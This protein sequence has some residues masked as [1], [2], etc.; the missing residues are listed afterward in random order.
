M[1]LDLR[2]HPAQVDRA[3]AWAPVWVLACLQAACPTS[4]DLLVNSITAASAKETLLDRLVPA[5]PAAPVVLA[6]LGHLLRSMAAEEALLKVLKDL[7]KDPRDTATAN[8]AL[9]LS[10]VPCRSREV[11]LQDSADHHSR[12]N[13][14][15]D[16]R[17]LPVVLAVPAD[18]EVLA[19]ADHRSKARCRS[20]LLV[21]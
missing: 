19:R 4:L 8:L 21:T 9:L 5:A 7:I 18:R 13:H 2:A 1:L 6:A 12:A 17:V 14:R 10:S 16:L 3:R 20:D 11:S 15:L